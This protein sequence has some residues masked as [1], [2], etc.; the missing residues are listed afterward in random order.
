[1]DY[2]I[3]NSDGSIDAENKHLNQY[4]QQGSD[5]VNHFF[6][7][8]PGALST[9]VCEAVFTLPNGFSTTVDIDGQ[10]QSD[11]DV[12]LEEKYDGWLFTLHESVTRYPG[13]LVVAIRVIRDNTVLVN[14]PFTLVVNETGVRPEM[15]TGIT[16][17]QLDEFLENIENY[18]DSK[19][20]PSLS[21]SSENPVQ[22]KVVTAALN[23][24]LS[25]SDFN[26]QNGC[27]DLRSWSSD[28]GSKKIKEF[29]DAGFRGPKLYL[30]QI[31]G[32]PVYFY[33]ADLNSSYITI[34][35][36]EIGSGSSY[37]YRYVTHFTYNDNTTFYNLYNQTQAYNDLT[38]QEVNPSNATPYS[39]FRESTQAFF[40]IFDVVYVGSCQTVVENQVYYLEIECLSDARRWTKTLNGSEYTTSKIYDD[41]MVAANRADYA[42]KNDVVNSY[43]AKP[44]DWDTTPT[45]DSTKPV[46]SGGVKAA[47]D[48]AIASTYKLMGSA[49]VSA[50]NDMTKSAGLNGNVY[51]I[52]GPGGSLTNAATT[53]TVV[54]S[55]DNVVFL[56]NN[57][58][59]LWDNLGSIVDLSNYLEKNSPITGA[60]KTKITYD[61][62][63]LVT[64]GADLAPA[65]IPSLDASKIAT[66][67]LPDSRIASA[68]TWNGK[69]EQLVSG[70]SI[71]TINGQSVLGSGDI[72]IAPQITGL[73]RHKIYLN[74]DTPTMTSDT[75]L[76]I[77]SASSS[78]ITNSTDLI[79]A[80]GNCVSAYFK[81]KDLNIGS[82]VNKQMT[83]SVLGF[84]LVPSPYGYYLYYM[85]ESGVVASITVS[86]YNDVVESI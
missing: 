10:Y 36:T 21:L 5:G 71:K 2:I 38:I 33:V 64:G 61:S 31:Y 6:V 43:S 77:V 51:N 66:G 1:M 75:H 8:Y 14:Y 68:A 35:F 74:G 60:T 69:Q 78:Q 22:N 37:A 3:F 23:E 27:I 49:L 54:N 39:V 50:L 59:W 42:L 86:S 47:I 84:Q 73:F 79:N 18:I 34:T 19:T 76:E 17:N 65:D 56:W 63:G 62:N 28:I 46:T 45:D 16:L 32:F 12:G 13:L 58:S 30:A 48:A 80:L 83:Y 40:K 44:S 11:Y 52:T 41:I 25:I 53:A 82:N 26:S 55:G 70:T 67:T 85:K 57:G 4:I 72:Q 9:D 20:D 7:A 81:I 29:Y 24:K 15:D